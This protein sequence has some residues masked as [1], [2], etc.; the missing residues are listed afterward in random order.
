MSHYISVDDSRESRLLTESDV[1]K[2]MSVSLAVVRRWRM[3]GRGPRCLKLGHLVRYRSEDIEKWLASRPVRG[4][5]LENCSAPD[6]G[7]VKAG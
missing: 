3:E 4:E 5:R 1:A 2:M 6:A 7:S